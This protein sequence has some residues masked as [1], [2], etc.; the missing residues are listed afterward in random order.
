MRTPTARRR[1]STSIGSNSGRSVSASR[2]SRRVITNAP[3]EPTQQEDGAPGPT[4]HEPGPERERCRGGPDGRRGPIRCDSA[5]VIP[6]RTLR[7]GDHDGLRGCDV[8][9]AHPDVA[10]RRQDHRLGRR[11]RGHAGHFPRVRASPR[12]R[13][14]RPHGEPTP[15]AATRT[16]RPVPGRSASARP[17]RIVRARDWADTRR[18]KGSHTTSITASRTDVSIKARAIKPNQA[19]SPG[20]QRVSIKAHGTGPPHFLRGAACSSRIARSCARS[21]GVSRLF[22]TM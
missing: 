9:Q 19:S 17:G 13:I 12:S 10:R 2:I 15:S 16:T 21:S 8:R 3:E 14:A 5:T 20:V 4:E 22:L 11:H 18:R 7:L 1:A 6:G